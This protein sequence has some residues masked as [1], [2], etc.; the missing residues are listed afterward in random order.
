MISRSQCYKWFQRFE[1]GNESLEDEEHRRRPQVVDDELLKKAI[2]SDPTQTTKKLTLELGCSNSTIDEH[3]HTIG[4]INRSLDALDN[5]EKAQLSE[6]SSNMRRNIHNQWA[7]FLRKHG[8]TACI[9]ITYLAP[10]SLTISSYN[11][12]HST[13]IRHV[14]LYEFESGHTSAEAHRKL[15]QVFG[16]E[17]PS[18]RSVRAWFQR[19]KAGN[20]KLK[21]EPRSSRPT[22]ESVD[23]YREQWTANSRNGGKARSMAPTCSDGNRKG[24]LDI[25]TQLLSRSRRFDWL[26]T[27]VTGDEKWVLYVNHIPQTCAGD[28]MPYPFVKGEIHEKK[29]MLSV[30][31]SSWNLTFRTAAGQHDSYCGGLVRSTAKTGR[32][33]PQ[34]APKARQRSPA[35]R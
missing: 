15:S 19:F 2:E 17:T 16:T 27:I 29:V 13:H 33:D 23:Q 14:L 1:N 3:L 4:K 10:S 30:W 25:C 18:E 6:K 32:Q 7:E 5:G 31:W 8:T 35:A 11:G 26:D 24:L 22:V 9:H 28:E 20:K 21:D 12:E 34:G